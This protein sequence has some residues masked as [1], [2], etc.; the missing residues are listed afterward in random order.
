MNGGGGGGQPEQAGRLARAL[1]RSRANLAPAHLRLPASPPPNHHPTPLGQVLI[2]TT[3]G[4]TVRFNP[5]LYNEG[6]VGALV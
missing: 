1:R 2:R 3:G 6:K 5:N 4:G